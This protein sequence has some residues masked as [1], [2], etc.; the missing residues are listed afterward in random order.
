[1][2]VIGYSISICTLPDMVFASHATQ[3]DDSSS[4]KVQDVV[5]STSALDFSGIDFSDTETDL[6]PDNPTS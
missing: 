4:T 2:K 5:T 3:S 1:M 6:T